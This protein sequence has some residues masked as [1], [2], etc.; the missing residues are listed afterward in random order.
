MAR[1]GINIEQISIIRQAGGSFEPDPVNAA[2][3]VEIGGADGIVCPLRENLQFITERDIRLLKEVIKTHLNIRISP[4]SQLITLALSVSPD[5][6]T[7]VPGKKPGSTQGGGLDVLGRTDELTKVIH[8]VRAQ[9]IVISLLIE[10]IIHQVKAAAKVG[11]D[12]IELHLGRYAAAEDLNQRTD[13]LENISSIALAASKIGL[14]VAAN[15]GLSYQNVSEIAAIENIEEI[16][17]GHAVISR[18]LWIGMEQAV[19]DMVALVH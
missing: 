14:G 10:P 7:I 2:V 19:R 8:D 1:L 15:H 11:A 3:M 6:I 18:A 16:N 13:M 4:T 5:M 9:D 17:I 12:Y